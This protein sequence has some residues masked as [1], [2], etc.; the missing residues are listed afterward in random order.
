MSHGLTTKGPVIFGDGGQA[1]AAGSFSVAEGQRLPVLA[2]SPLRHHLVVSFIQ[3]RTDTGQDG[4]VL[5]VK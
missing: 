4:S 2:S 1:G 5:F 3:L